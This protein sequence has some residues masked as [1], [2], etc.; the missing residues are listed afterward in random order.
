MWAPCR[1]RAFH[2]FYV[3]SAIVG[4]PF[5]QICVTPAVSECDDF[6]VALASNGRVCAWGTNGGSLT[7]PYVESGP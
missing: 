2:I 5:L 3:H 6:S 7:I 4:L 1:A